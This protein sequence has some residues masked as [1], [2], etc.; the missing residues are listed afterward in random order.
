MI[1]EHPGEADDRAVPGH[2][3]GDLLIG[4]E[5][6]AI[7]TLVERNTRFTMLVHLPR[8]EGFVIIPRTNNGPA[9]A[10][11]GAVKMKDALA[12][13]MSGLPVQLRR[14]QHPLSSLSSQPLTLRSYRSE[15]S[16]EMHRME[17]YESGLVMREPPKLSLLARDPARALEFEMPSDQ[18]EYVQGWY[19]TITFPDGEVTPGIYDHRDLLPHYGLPDDLTGKRALDVA[20]ANGY[21]AFE[22]ERRGAEV[23]AVDVASSSEM[24]FPPQVL[25]LLRTMPLRRRGDRFREAHARLGSRV[26][27]M[28][29]SVYDLAEERIGN[30]DLVHAGDILLHLERPLDALRRLRNVVDV[31]GQLI[32][33]DTVDPNLPSR[34]HIFFHTIYLGGWDTHTWWYPSIDTLGQM[35]IDTG[36]TTVELH[37]LYML[38][39]RGQ[40]EGPW[41]AVFRARP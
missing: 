34:Q 25:A 8:E 19:H 1:S 10:G 24:D 23:T 7:G 17:G 18:D 16:V 27:Y 5:R 32:L 40:S 13:T 36:F 12:S 33:S 29:M 37:L 15:R 26:R 30:F 31:D 9:L 39:T 3:E 11:Y 4:L 21:F 41:R 28:D 20:T 14:G 2:W 35:I 22:M 38:P 6:S